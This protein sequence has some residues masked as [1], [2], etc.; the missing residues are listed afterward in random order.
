MLLRKLQQGDVVAEGVPPGGAAVERIPPARF[1]HANLVLEQ[2]EV[3]LA[4][5]IASKGRGGD[6]IHRQAVR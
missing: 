2:S 1:V 5:H 4:E 3:L 6:F